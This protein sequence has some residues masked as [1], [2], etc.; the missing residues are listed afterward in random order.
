MNPIPEVNA[1]MIRW[2]MNQVNQKKYREEIWEEHMNLVHSDE[3]VCQ[4]GCDRMPLDN[5]NR[6]FES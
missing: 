2:I 4:D 1:I 6:R 5:P 3:S